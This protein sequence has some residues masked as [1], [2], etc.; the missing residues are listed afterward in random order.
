MDA[1]TR[2]S[3]RFRLGLHSQ[4]WYLPLSK[5]LIMELLLLTPVILVTELCINPTHSLNPDI[6]IYVRNTNSS[7]LQCSVCL[8]RGYALY[9][10]WIHLIKF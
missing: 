9:P 2:A 10:C 1:P 3:H 8:R 6:Y 4:L 5:T 7:V